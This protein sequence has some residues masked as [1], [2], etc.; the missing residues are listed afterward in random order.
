MIFVSAGH[1]LKDPGAQGSGTSENIEMMKFRD[2]VCSNLTAA[3]VKFIKDDDKETLSQY[4]DRIKTGEGSVVLEFHLDS[5]GTGKATGTTC[6]VGVD[7]DRLDKAFAKELVDITAATFGIT[8]RGVKSE[9][10]SHVKRLAIMREKGIVA[11]LELCFIDNAN[12][13]SAFN[14]H[15]SNLAKKI[16]DILIKYENMIP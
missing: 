1:H 14:A 2:L 7:A 4:L 8:N 6:L 3:G 9:A 15:K 12:D 16:S 13:M 10:E 5:S 11:L